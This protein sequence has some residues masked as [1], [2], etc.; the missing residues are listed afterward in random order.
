MHCDNLKKR[1]LK[2]VRLHCANTGCSWHGFYEQLEVSWYKKEGG[3][4][5][6]ASSEG[7]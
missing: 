6:L 5:E 2:D 7:M 3:E 1:E 4:E